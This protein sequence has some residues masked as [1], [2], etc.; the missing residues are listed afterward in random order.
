MEVRGVGG[1]GEAG[2]FGVGSRGA[3]G[4]VRLTRWGILGSGSYFLMV[5]FI[6]SPRSLLTRLLGH[7]HFRVI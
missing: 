4:S 2:G 3:G 1:G 5:E 6:K 7:F